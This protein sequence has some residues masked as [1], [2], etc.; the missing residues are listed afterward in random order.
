MTLP[1]QHFPAFRS[2]GIT[3]QCALACPS[4]QNAHDTGCGIAVVGSDA[5]VGG[6]TTVV[7]L[8]SWGLWMNSC[9]VVTALSALQLDL[10]AFQ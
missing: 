5:A 1:W 3:V 8:V 6:H 2:V 4:E 7:P 9:T 10:E